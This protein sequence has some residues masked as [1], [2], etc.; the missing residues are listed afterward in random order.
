MM[1]RGLM[2]GAVLLALAMY[3]AAVLLLEQRLAGEL[4]A[5]C[6][7]LAALLALVPNAA[8]LGIYIEDWIFVKE[9]RAADTT[10]AILLIQADGRVWRLCG[11]T[12]CW[13]GATLL[14]IL[15]W[16]QFATPTNQP[17]IPPS[18]A[19]M[20]FLI[21]GAGISAWYCFKEMGD[22]Q[23]MNRLAAIEREAAQTASLIVR[24]GEGAGAEPPPRAL[25][26]NGTVA[27]GETAAPAGPDPPAPAP[28]DGR[29]P[30]GGDPP[31]GPPTG[32]GAIQTVTAP[33]LVVLP[34]APDPP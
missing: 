12:G 2:I 9:S 6:L 16:L 1:K 21:G 27:H 5:I 4:T 23:Q 34:P 8:L 30:T 17:P 32:D 26:I 20:L 19:T 14:G 10:A 28:A 29:S 15:F 13:I 7:T 33:V 3:T 22:R 31:P 11:R 25:A 24:P 18:W